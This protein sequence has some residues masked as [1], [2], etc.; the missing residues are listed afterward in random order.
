MSS[1]GLLGSVGATMS[2]GRTAV[3]RHR[4]LQRALTA[5]GVLL[6]TAI[7]IALVVD[8]IRSGSPAG[9]G[10]GVAATQARS[11]PPFS[12]VDLLGDNNVIVRVGASQSV[13]VHADD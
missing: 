10:S 6:L 9:T 13:T 11:V 5:V 8:R 12:S 4:G 2:S 1:R 3:P 7:V